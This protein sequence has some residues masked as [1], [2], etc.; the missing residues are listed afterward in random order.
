MPLAKGKSDKIVSKNIATEI[1]AGRPRAQAIAIAYR[2]AG[3]SKSDGGGSK[4][5]RSK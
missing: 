4:K 2:E 5:S 1:R 3:R